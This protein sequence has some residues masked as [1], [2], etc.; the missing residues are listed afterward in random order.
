MGR[1]KELDRMRDAARAKR[2]EAVS[3]LKYL[4]SYMAVTRE[5]RK[6]RLISKRKRR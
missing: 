6:C 3:F 5:G 4:I 2:A 1:R